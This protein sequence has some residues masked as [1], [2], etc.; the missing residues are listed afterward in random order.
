MGTPGF[1]RKMIACLGGAAVGAAGLA[2]VF[3]QKGANE[4]GSAKPLSPLAEA[5]MEANTPRSATAEA[6][7]E[8]HDFAS[9]WLKDPD[10]AR[11]SR[12]LSEMGEYVRT[13][14]ATLHSFGVVTFQKFDLKGGENPLE[15]QYQ[16]QTNP[17]ARAAIAADMM[18][19]GLDNLKLLVRRAGRDRSSDPKELA[20]L[21]ES[22]R[23]S[24]EAVSRGAS[25]A[26]QSDNKR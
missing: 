20:E 25:L 10:R 24:L 15:K 2:G 7:K 6:Q 19:G 12:E 16:V 23:L 13:V 21:K 8:L 26:L 18:S 11:T 1:D 14:S 9:M 17:L 5:R 4:H 3:S 22:F